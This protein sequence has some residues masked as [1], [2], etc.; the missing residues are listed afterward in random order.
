[1][2][3]KILIGILIFLI[4]LNLATIGSYLYVQWRAPRFPAAPPEALPPGPELRLDRAQQQQLRMLLR[5]FKQE[6]QP[7]ERRAQE[8]EERIFEL[9]QEEPVSREE[10]EQHLQEISRLRFEISKRMLAKFEETR[11][12]LSPVQQKRFYELLMRARP[13]PPEGRR[14]AFRRGPA[15]PP[16]LAPFPDGEAV[17]SNEIDP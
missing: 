8:L 2:K 17:D 3:L 10:I 15:A 9:L 4:A 13:A 12:F 11:E 6:V 14:P 1:M 7:L 5:D 16:H